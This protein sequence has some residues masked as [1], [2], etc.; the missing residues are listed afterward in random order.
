[1]FGPLV[2]IEEPTNLADLVSLLANNRGKARLVAGGTDVVVDMRTIGIRPE[3]LVSLARVPGLREIEEVDGEL[4]LGTLV[5]PNAIVA[6]GLIRQRLPALADAARCMGSYQVRNLATLGGNICRASP[7]ADLPPALIAAGAEIIIQSAAGKDRRSLQGF[8]LD[9]GK[10]SLGEA[11]VLT[12]FVIPRQPPC[13]GISYM[14]FKLREANAL[15]VAASAVRLT[16]D[17]TDKIVDAMVVLGAVAPIPMVAVKSSKML[18]GKKPSAELFD[19]VALKASQ[20]ARPISDVRGS[21]AHRRSLVRVL[22]RRALDEAL[23]RA[24]EGKPA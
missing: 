9:V 16:L 21:A 23:G 8:F 2:S 13:S 20:E 7:S 17:E 1:M 6:S 14:P 22:T 3:L 12:H 19:K 10:T 18:R 24:R 4:L 15:A 11:E 5:T